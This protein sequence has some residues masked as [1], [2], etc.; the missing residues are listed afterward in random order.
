M[1]IESFPN[2]S[3]LEDIWIACW[4][5]C[6]WNDSMCNFWLYQYSKPQTGLYWQYFPHCW[7]YKCWELVLMTLTVYSNNI[8]PAWSLVDVFQPP[9]VLCH[10]IQTVESATICLW[11]KWI[12]GNIMKM[13]LFT[14]LMSCVCLLGLQD[15]VNNSK[16]E[17]QKFLSSVD[18]EI[19]HQGTRK[20]I[21]EMKAFS[22]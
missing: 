1:V 15:Y 22:S 19:Q 9:A 7:A 12:L 21:V 6:T 8:H 11:S 17:Q 14:R 3:N 20:F 4:I 13:I 10:L 18:L 5:L 16:I 2:F